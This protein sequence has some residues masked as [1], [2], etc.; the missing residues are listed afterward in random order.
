MERRKRVW[1]ERRKRCRLR[2]EKGIGGEMKKALM[3]R[4][5]KVINGEREKSMGQRG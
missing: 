1:V 4:E 2:G 5:G 3:E